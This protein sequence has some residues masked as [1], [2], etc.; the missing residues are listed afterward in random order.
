MLVK[1]LSPKGDSANK[2]NQNTLLHPTELSLKKK[3]YLRQNQ[4]QSRISTRIQAFWV[5]RT[6]SRG[7]RVRQARIKI[8]RCH[9]RCRPNTGLWTLSNW[10]TMFSRQCQNEHAR[11]H[12][13][14]NTKEASQPTKSKRLKI[15]S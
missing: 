15:H 6:S 13:S 1:P 10:Q 11:A 4:I 12:S 14:L 7:M 2:F 9:F 8:V 5:S 3:S